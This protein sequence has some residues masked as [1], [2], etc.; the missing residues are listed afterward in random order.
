MGSEFLLPGPLT[1][2]LRLLDLGGSASFWQTAL[3]SLGRILLGFLA[4]AA[5]GALLA[6]LTGM[7]AWLESLLSPAI[8]VVRAVPVVSFILLLQLWLR[9]G[10]VPAVCAALMV[11]PVVWENVSKGIRE[12]DPLLLE[13]ARAW[14]FSRGKTLGLIYLPSVL[15]YFASAC[16]SGLGLAWK[17]GVAAEVLALP[18]L[19][20]GL[21]M[22]NS[23]KYLETPDLFAWSVVVIALSFLLERGLKVLFRHM[24]RGRVR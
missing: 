3:M 1:T 14:G 23:K 18:K 15:P 8:R 16:A 21:E 4:G 11:M 19:A 10:R 17:S 24:E 7:S 22:S 13:G 5:A 20:I 2:L 6:A 12:T 9:S